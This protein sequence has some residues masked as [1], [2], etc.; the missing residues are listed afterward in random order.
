MLQVINSS[1]ASQQRRDRMARFAARYFAGAEAARHAGAE[2]VVTK[3]KGGRP[4]LRDRAMTV[5]ERMRRYRAKRAGVEREGPLA[6][7]E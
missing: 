5:A 4:P 7:A 3:R 6:D 2:A 1:K